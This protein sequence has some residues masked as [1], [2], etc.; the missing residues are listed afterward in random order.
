MNDV[1][2]SILVSIIMF[3]WIAYL[4]VIGVKF[5]ENIGRIYLGKDKKGQDEEVKR[6]RKEFMVMLGR[7]FFIMAGSLI[8]LA[9]ISGVLVQMNK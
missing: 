1:V 7:G 9:I 2:K 5:Y 8:L 6:V 4:L 3:S